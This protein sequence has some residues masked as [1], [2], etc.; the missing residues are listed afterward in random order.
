MLVVGAEEEVEVLE[1][2]VPREVASGA[3][4]VEAGDTTVESFMVSGFLLNRH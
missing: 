2:G 4:A 3:V 1:E